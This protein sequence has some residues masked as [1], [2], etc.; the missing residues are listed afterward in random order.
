MADSFTF[1]TLGTLHCEQEGKYDAARQATAADDAVHGRLV[2]DGSAFEHLDHALDDVDGFSHV[3]LVYVFHK[4]ADNWRPHVRPPR[5]DR[6]IGVL[7]T[8]APYRPNPIGMSVVPLLAVDRA[9]L[10]LEIGRHDLLDGT[11]VIDIKP[12]VAHC[13]RIEPP[14]RQGW[15]DGLAQD[16]DGDLFAVTI[17][18]RAQ[19]Q[20]DALNMPAFVTFL[21]QQLAVEPLSKKRKRLRLLD[22]DSWKPIETT[23]TSLAQAPPPS[24][25]L[26][27]VAYK[28]WRAVFSADTDAHTVDVLCIR[29]GWRSC[30]LVTAE[31]DVVGGGDDDKY[32]RDKFVHRSFLDRFGWD[33]VR[34]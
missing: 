22:R 12:Y 4:S 3:W 25:S 28:T 21:R 15:L 31:G 13:D 17:G 19:N 8:R 5:G 16:G 11:P 7:A 14:L 29:S 23:S 1:R 30:E 10:T 32:A 33:L 20:L 24:P 6:R 2:L 18:E 9:A 27:E 26:W 34:S